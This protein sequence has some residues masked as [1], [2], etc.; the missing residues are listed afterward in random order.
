MIYVICSFA[1]MLFECARVRTCSSSISLYIC[2]YLLLKGLWAAF[3][4][5]VMCGRF[6]LRFCLC[7]GRPMRPM[8]VYPHA[9]CAT[10]S[11]TLRPLPLP[12]ARHS[13]PGAHA[14]QI[15]LYFARHVVRATRHKRCGHKATQQACHKITTQEISPIIRQAQAPQPPSAGYDA[16]LHPDTRE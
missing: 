15:F 12:R 10:L 4:Y 6:F 8:P 2:A 11:A 14:S 3:V 9:P 5:C 7:G 13:R 16:T 1:D